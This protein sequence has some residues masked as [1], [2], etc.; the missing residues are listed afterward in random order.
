MTNYYVYFHVNSLT[1]EIFY[2]G[3]G[4]CNRAFA[5]TRRSDRWLNYVNKYKYYV[6][7]VKDGMTNEDALELESLLIETIGRK[8]RLQGPLINMTDG[9]EG[10]KGKVTSSETKLKMSIAAKGRKMS[11]EQKQKLSK[12][13]KGKKLSESHKASITI[14]LL[15]AYE[16]KAN[17]DNS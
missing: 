7:I 11:S 4:N 10:G 8:D 5:K 3:K 1:N 12:L 2:V 13:N 9:G 15:K 17:T 6:R 14:G 16:R